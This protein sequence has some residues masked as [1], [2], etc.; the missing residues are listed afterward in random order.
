MLGVLFSGGKDSTY[1]VYA[2]LKKG[3]EVKCLITL[4]SENRASYMFHTAAIDV[5]KL[6]AEA[7]GLPIMYFPTKGEKE[8][9]LKDLENALKEA[10]KKYG[11]NGIGVG[12]LASEY[13]RERVQ[14]ICDNLGLEMFAPLWKRN[15][16]EYLKELVS[17]GFDVRF[18]GVGAYGLDEEWLGRKLD[19]KA[20]SG[21]VSLHKKYGIH[22]GGEGGEYETLV[23]DCPKFMKKISILESSPK[24]DS[25]NSGRLEVISAKLENK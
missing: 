19:Q 14:K 5:T 12:A 9:E 17:E 15:Q 20:V 3:Y 13:Q 10:K 4:R 11:L 18:V 24:M 6:Q 7:L 1:T 2:A 25:E 21:L 16:E 23:L 8:K 22:I